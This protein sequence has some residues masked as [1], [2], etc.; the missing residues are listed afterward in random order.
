MKDDEGDEF[1]RKKD[2]DDGKD[3]RIGSGIGH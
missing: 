3:S 2:S 1:P